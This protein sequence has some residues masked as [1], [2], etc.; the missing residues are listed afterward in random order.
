MEPISDLRGREQA[1]VQACAGVVA[2][3][4]LITDG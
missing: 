1:G 2:K 4:L 3:D